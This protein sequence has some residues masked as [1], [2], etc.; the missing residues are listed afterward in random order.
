MQLHVVF[1]GFGCFI[2]DFMYKVFAELPTLFARF[3]APYLSSPFS[4]CEAP[5]CLVAVPS[6]SVWC[7]NN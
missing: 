5:P 2:A 1:V 4:A 6:V 7:V 3:S